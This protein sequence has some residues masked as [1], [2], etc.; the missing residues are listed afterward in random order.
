[1]QHQPWIST[2]QQIA[3]LVDSVVYV[4]I[5]SLLF[6]LTGLITRLLHRPFLSRFYHCIRLHIRQLVSMRDTTLPWRLNPSTLSLVQCLSQSDVIIRSNM[7][8]CRNLETLL[9]LPRTDKRKNTSHA[10]TNWET[11]MSSAHDSVPSRTNRFIRMTNNHFAE[12]AHDFVQ[13]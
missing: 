1:V 7:L 12:F 13:L 4:N 8:L 5:C 3:R 2:L 11:R 9:E 6:R 10:K